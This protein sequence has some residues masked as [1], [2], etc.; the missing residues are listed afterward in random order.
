MNTWDLWDQIKGKMPWLEGAETG[1][2]GQKT[3]TLPGQATER[4]GGMFGYGGVLDQ[5]K[6]MAKQAW[7]GGMEKAGEAVDAGKD[8]FMGE[9][10]WTP[11]APTN[12]SRTGVHSSKSMEHLETGLKTA[13]KFINKA[14]DKGDEYADQILDWAFPNREWMKTKV[15]T[16]D[17]KKLNSIVN[18]MPDSHRKRKLLGQMEK[19]MTMPK[20]A[21]R[22]RKV[23]DIMKQI[24]NISMEA[25]GVNRSAFS[26][27]T[28]IPNINTKNPWSNR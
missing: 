5:G 9:K 16:E 6:D 2:L 13:D 3:T 10:V 7:S 8:Y 22:T 23:Q 14:V 19:T 4:S 1:L 17:K 27:K 28:F 20:S 12:L 24:N 18:N 26:P 25:R 15:S 11:D 21:D